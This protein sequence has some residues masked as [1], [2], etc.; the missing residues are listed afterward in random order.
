[1]KEKQI[2]KV[3]DNLVNKEI[4]FGEARDKLFLLY[5]VV[6]SLPK[7]SLEQAIENAKPNLNKIKDV[8]KHIDN[9]R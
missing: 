5:G 2:I 4:T 9:I 6:K 7:I 1:M 8:D 3:L